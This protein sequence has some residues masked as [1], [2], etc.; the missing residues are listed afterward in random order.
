MYMLA[1][2]FNSSIKKAAAARELEVEKRYAQTLALI[3][4]AHKRHENKLEQ[5]KK[6]SDLKS[7]NINDEISPAKNKAKWTKRQCEHRDIHYV[8]TPAIMSQSYTFFYQFAE[9]MHAYVEARTDLLLCRAKYDQDE[10]LLEYEILLERPERIAGC[11]RDLR[12]HLELQPY[13]KA[14]YEWRRWHL[15]YTMH[16]FYHRLI[17]K[18]PEEA[19]DIAAQ[20]VAGIEPNTSSFLLRPYFEIRETYYL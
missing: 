20:E 18:K 12:R 17:L 16:F 1:Y 7:W 13:L 11:R 14:R 15:T 10:E 4:N 3:E 19:A 9:K 5:I 6:W 2:K 8:A